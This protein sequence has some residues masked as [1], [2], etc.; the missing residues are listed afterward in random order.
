MLGIGEGLGYMHGLKIVHGDLKGVNVLI[1][2]PPSN[3]TPLLCD[4]GLSRAAD[5][6]S[7]TTDDQGN[8]QGTINWMAIELFGEGG[9]DVGRWW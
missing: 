2:G 7:P 5:I 6:P 4:F 1:S 3:P 9:G 8:I